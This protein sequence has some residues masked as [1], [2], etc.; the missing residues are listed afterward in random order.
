MIKSI[1]SAFLLLIS[2]F[3]LATDVEVTYVESVRGLDSEPYA[4]NFT[5]S[6]KNSWHNE[7]NRDAAWVFFKLDLEDGSRHQYLKAG[8]AKM[9][10]KGAN[11]MPDAKI[12]VAEDGAGLFVFPGTKYRGDI[13]Y[14]ITVERDTTKTNFRTRFERMEAIA[15]EMVYIPEGGFTLGDPLKEALNFGAFYQSDSNGD[16][17]GLF[18]ITSASQ[19]IPVGPDKGSLYYQSRNNIYQGDQKGTIPS[20]FPNGYESFYIM[21][22]E[23]TQGQYARFL[24]LI[25]K[26]A[27]TVRVNFGSP[28]YKKHGGTIELKDGKYVAAAPDRRNVYFHWDDM[29]AFTDWAALRPY[30][31][32][33]FTK[34]CRGPL[35]PKSREYPWNTS[36]IDRMVNR[37]DPVTQE[38]VFLN[39]MTEAD[40]T[41][42]NRE[43]FGASYY[44]VMNLAGSMWEKV[45]TVGDEKGRSFKGVHGDGSISYYGYADVEDWPEGFREVE[46]YGYRGGGYY[47]VKGDITDF[48]PFS[49]IAFRRYGAWS[50]GPRNAAY[51]YRAARTA[52]T[53]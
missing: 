32:L 12:E 2:S 44:W 23:V 45:I 30:T 11:A 20:D 27:A 29:M 39:G 18:K 13:T 3:C 28:N 17:D 34:A 25:G 9:L 10:W 50:G 47:G 35:R 7:R 22:Y 1:S 4:I 14:H 15:I 16:F 51:G 43:I 42:E 52:P 53:D 21:K 36:S 5:I 41:E 38:Q 33:E 46:G 26:T 19:E 24:N 49:P 40:L 31:E 8:S 37:I 6:W 48:N